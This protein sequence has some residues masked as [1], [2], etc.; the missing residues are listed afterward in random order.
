MSGGSYRGRRDSKPSLIIAVAD[1]CFAAGGARTG[2]L[3]NM[4]E[5]TTT[6]TRFIVFPTEKVT[7]EMP[8]SRTM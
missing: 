4:T 2:F 7:G 1:H 8:W 6:A 5:E 3:K